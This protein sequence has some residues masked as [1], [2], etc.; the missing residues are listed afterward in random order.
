MGVLWPQQIF[1]S[2]PSMCSP[3]LPRLQPAVTLSL[4][5]AAEES[6]PPVLALDW[7]SPLDV[8]LRGH[9]GTVTSETHKGSPGTRCP[10]AAHLC[11]RDEALCPSLLSSSGSSF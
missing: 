6:C 1:S 8:F 2:C 3:F 7:L 10:A 4:A 11:G 9:G 5:V